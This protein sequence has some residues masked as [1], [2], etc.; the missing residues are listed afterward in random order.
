MAYAVNE[1]DIKKEDRVFIS[2]LGDRIGSLPKKYAR[3]FIDKGAALIVFDHDEPVEDSDAVEP[4]V[5]I[6]W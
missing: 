2:F 6:Y 4:Y 3:R 5:K 1:E